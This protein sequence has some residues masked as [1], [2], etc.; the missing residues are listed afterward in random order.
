MAAFIT[1]PSAVGLMVLRREVISVLFERGAFDAEAVDLTSAA[2]L[3]YAAGLFAFSGVRVMAPAFYAIK[4]TRTPVYIAAATLLSHVI[5][6]SL[7]SPRLGLPGIALSDSISATLNLSLLLLLFSRRNHMSLTRP[8]IG[9]VAVFAAAGGLM[10]VA[11][12]P[13]LDWTRSLL[14]ASRFQE[15]GALLITLSVMTIFYFVLCAA[16]GRDEPRRFL[17]AISL[18]RRRNPA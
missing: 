13:V 3:F 14:G 12:R 18:R 8:F 16:F 15:A 9:A 10:G 17:S 1:I 5:L 7:L 11:T 2:L 4:D 6:C